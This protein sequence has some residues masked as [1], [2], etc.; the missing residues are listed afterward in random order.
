MANNRIEE[1]KNRLSEVSESDQMV[2]IRALFREIRK[3]SESI[4]DKLDEGVAIS[5]FDQIKATF[6]N[7]LRS[8][9]KELRKILGQLKIQ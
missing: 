6:T 2:I 8:N 1:L 9:S 5:N 7:E 3:N 4:V